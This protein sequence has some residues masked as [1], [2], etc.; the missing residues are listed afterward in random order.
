M[1]LNLN[2]LIINTIYLQIKKMKIQIKESPITRDEKQTENDEH[3]QTVIY[4]VFHLPF[5]S[6][7]GDYSSNMDTSRLT[8]IGFCRRRLSDRAL[9]FI[10]N[11]LRQ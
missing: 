8:F 4:Y 11:L 9:F 1:Y 10:A 5:G 6:I 2:L 7:Y 3:Q